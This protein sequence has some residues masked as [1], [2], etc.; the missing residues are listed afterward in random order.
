MLL[1]ASLHLILVISFS[2]ENILKLQRK[3]A[4]KIETQKQM[5][6]MYE[7]GKNETKN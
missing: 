1:Q 6:Q 5:M 4:K 7:P 2:D 3:Y